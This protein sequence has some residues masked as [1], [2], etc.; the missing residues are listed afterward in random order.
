MQLNLE[1]VS[2]D[3]LTLLT[4]FLSMTMVKTKKKNKVKAMNSFQ[5][6]KPLLFVKLDQ[7]EIFL[8]QYAI[9]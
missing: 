6:N 7:D 8:C 1:P 9:N 4:Y 3:L 2:N 5:G